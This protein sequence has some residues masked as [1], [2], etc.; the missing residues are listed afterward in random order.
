VG[1]IR[2]YDPAR[3]LQ[4]LVARAWQEARTRRQVV[5][6]EGPWPTITL[7]PTAG[8]AVVAGGTATLRPYSPQHDLPSHARITFTPA[9]LYGPNHHHAADLEVLI[10]DLA[11]GASAGRIPEGVA[12]EEPCA[13]RDWPI[14]TRFTPTPAATD[15]IALWTRKPVTLTGTSSLLNI[16]LREVCTFYS[17]A[18]AVGLVVPAPGPASEASPARPVVAGQRRGFLR[19]AS[20]KVHVAREQEAGA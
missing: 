17:A 10:W 5:H 4:G 9:P 16:P 20:G 7:L 12:P 11:L 6:L 19:R 1:Q 18:H 3:Y 14:L 15:I 8:V 13:L 2:G